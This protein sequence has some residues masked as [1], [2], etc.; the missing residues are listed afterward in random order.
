MLGASQIEVLSTS[1][2]SVPEV[3]P[4]AKQCPFWSRRGR[5]T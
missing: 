1:L 2:A 3:Q 4:M 5:M